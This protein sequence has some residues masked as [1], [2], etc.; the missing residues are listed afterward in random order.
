MQQLGEPFI[1]QFAGF[2]HILLGIGGDTDADSALPVY[3]HDSAGRIHITF[4]YNRY[5]AQLDLAAGSSDYL[6]ADI[7]DG[8]ISAVGNNA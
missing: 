4:F 5:I 3:V 7:V 8:G 6:A 2:H 1:Y